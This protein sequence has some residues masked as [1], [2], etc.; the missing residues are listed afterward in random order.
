[1]NRPALRAQLRAKVNAAEKR[2]RELHA[3]RDWAGI[4]RA[5]PSYWLARNDWRAVE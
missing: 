5:L 2:L 3:M 4:Q 1:M